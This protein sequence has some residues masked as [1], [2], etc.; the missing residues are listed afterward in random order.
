MSANESLSISP[1]VVALD[2]TRVPET[3]SVEDIVVQ[4]SQGALL[5]VL[6]RDTRR[7]FTS[8]FPDII[9]DFKAGISGEAAVAVQAQI[10]NDVIRLRAARAANDSILTQVA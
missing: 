9:P 1:S 6:S 2:T 8:L 7:H 4:T 10:L 5:A 3:H